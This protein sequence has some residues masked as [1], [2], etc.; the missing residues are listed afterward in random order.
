MHGSANN[1]ILCL[2]AFGIIF[3]GCRGE[4]GKPGSSITGGDVRAPIVEIMHPIGNIPVFDRAFVES[5]ILHDDS[6]ESVELVVD[7]LQTLAVNWQNFDIRWQTLLNC[8]SLRLGRHT[9]QVLA[10]DKG[11]RLGMSPISVFE[12]VSLNE[13]PD[14]VLLRYFDP[15]DDDGFDWTIPARDALYTG[16][17][18][19]FT[20]D[21]PCT[22]AEF[23]VEIQRDTSWQGTQ[24]VYEVRKSEDGKPAEVL[25]DELFNSLRFRWFPGVE[26]VWLKYRGDDYTIDGEF[27]ITCTLKE[28]AT[29]DTLALKS[30]SGRWRNWHGVVKE[31]GEWKD[32]SDGE[33]I[34]WNP[35]IYV[36]VKYR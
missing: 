36:W 11:N 23:W 35:H 19:R 12:K 4:A 18:V 2:A 9:I 27:F 25:Q 33:S 3:Q 13:L 16:F 24:L 28:E 10:R 29:G 31:H 6:L 26:S 7:G 21:R 17:G 22:V 1:I 8:E 20:P 30:D 15:E 5:R 32:F 34:T 14:S